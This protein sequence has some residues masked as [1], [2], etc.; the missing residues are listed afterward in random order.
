MDF[1]KILWCTFIASSMIGMSASSLDCCDFECEDEELGSCELFCCKPHFAI[2]SQASNTART[3]VGRAKDVHLAGY[4]DKS[5]HVANV[6]FGYNR[7]FRTQDEIG[8]YFSPACTNPC[9][10]CGPCMNFGADNEDI[11]DI[12]SADFGTTCTG[13]L[14]LCPR[15]SNIVAEFDWFVGLHAFCEGLFFDIHI[16]IVYSRWSSGCDTCTGSC[17]DTF[18]PGLMSQS[19]EPVDVGTECICDAA[20]GNF[21]WGDVLHPMKYGKIC[22]GTLTT[23]QLADLQIELGYDFI[24]EEDSHLGAKLILKIPSGNT[25]KSRFVFEPIVGNEGHFEFGAGLTAHYVL[26]T[27]NN[28]DRF[29]WYF[30]G[31]VTHLFRGRRQKRLFDLKKNGCFSRYLLLKTFT[32]GQVDGLERG[33]NIFAQEV[34]TSFGVQVDI[35]TLFSYQTECW[36]YELGYNFWARSHEN[37]K[38][39]CCTIPTNTFGIKGTQL[40]TNNMTASLSTIKENEGTQGANDGSDPHFV[41]C[42]DLDICS[43]LVPS[44]ISHSVV[45]YLG[46][47][48]DSDDIKVLEPY[49]GIGAQVEFSGRDNAALDQ[50]HIW[51]KGGWSW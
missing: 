29:V 24:L 13:S 38:E 9:S 25:P 37:L 10:G 6:T 4:P 49:I 32:T 11:I 22:S 34:R 2:R 47:T 18:E 50:W 35:T 20:N 44:A 26:F 30:E 12:R 5:Y 39:L 31:D 7:S 23:T 16:P 1:K 42:S 45:G 43:A 51:L 40:M 17:T 15:V 8:T 27:R 14:C 41:A 46:Y 48:V 19:N 33:P 3:L 28:S 36:D 21:E